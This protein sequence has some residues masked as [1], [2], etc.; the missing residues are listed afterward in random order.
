MASKSLSL[1]AALLTPVT[2]SGSLDAEALRK[3][4]EFVLAAGVEGICVNGATGEYPRW[5]RDVREA[6]AETARDA[7]DGRGRLIVGIGAVS[8]AESIA[9]GQHALDHG[10]DLLLLP[11]PHYFRYEP[12]DIGAFYHAAAHSLDGEIL[13]YNLPVFTN[14]VE[15]GWTARL[16]A[17]VPNITGAKDSSGSL[18][19]LTALER[20]GAPVRWMGHDS[21]ITR[22]L[23]L[24]VANGA[25]SGVAGVFPETLRL[26]LDAHRDGS[27]PAEADAALQEIV[28]QISVLPTPWALKQLAECRGLCATTDYASAVSR[29]RR[30]QLD[31]LKRWFEDWAERH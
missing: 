6:A 19:S 5:G 18:A 9:L 14:P 25:I 16:V 2:R 3:N 31:D 12:E 26:L 27:D 8:L 10:A 15:A 24:G 20:V 28:K 23:S 4:V 11:P 1:S 7:L 17:E 29:Q 22:A 30:K 21:E 13:I